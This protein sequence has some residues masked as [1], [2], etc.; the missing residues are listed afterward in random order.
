MKAILLF[1]LFGLSLCCDTSDPACLGLRVFVQSCRNLEDEDKFGGKSDPYITLEVGHHSHSLFHQ[2]FQTKTITDN[3][4]PEWNEVFEFAG[5]SD[6]QSKY[7]FI[8]VYDEDD[9]RSE[10]IGKYKLPLADL[11]Q[12]HPTEFEVNV[13]EGHGILRHAYCKVEVTALNWGK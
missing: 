12:Y 8:K 2:K 9:V 6:P 10:K 4:N 5:I 3:L 1:A 13:G 7:L 11:V